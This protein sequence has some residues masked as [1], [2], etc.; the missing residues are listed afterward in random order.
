MFDKTPELYDLFYEG[1]D[2]RGE[3]ARVHD[4]V[5]ARKPAA[6]TLLDVACGTGTH[7]EHLGQWFDV[8]GLDLDPGLLDVAR[9]RLPDVPLHVADM[10][11][12]D[13]GRAFDVVTCL[14]SS[15]GY[16]V[17]L[18]GLHQ[19]V[20]SMAQ[21]LASDGMLLLEPWL[22]PDRFDPSH[23][24]Q[25][26]VVEGDGFNAVRTNSSRVEGDRSILEFHYLVTRP[27]SVEH[28]TETHTL[29]LFTEEDHRRA[30]EAAG[31]NASFDVDGLMG[32]GL[33]TAWR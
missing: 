15:I 7:L 12:F 25:V 13:L 11:A 1:K 19:A 30:F 3:A 16:V 26:I 17:T 9:R 27:G 5:H 14:F 33:W 4:L 6:R 28:V 31:L 2:Y 29:G 10:R 32:R 8:E 24:A 21:H 18:D 23:P 22:S 20:A